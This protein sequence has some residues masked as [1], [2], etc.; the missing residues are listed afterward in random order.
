MHRLI[1]AIQYVKLISIPLS[2]HFLHFFAQS[3]SGYFL[4]RAKKN[5]SGQI[6]SLNAFR[7]LLWPEDF[8]G[9]SKSSTTSWK[10]CSV[11]L[12]L[13]IDMGTNIHVYS[14]AYK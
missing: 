7:P 13:D 14:Y 11:F 12:G 1:H 2:Q 9:M 5:G 6:F 10:D 4:A 3:A 8:V